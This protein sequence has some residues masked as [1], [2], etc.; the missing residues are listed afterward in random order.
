MD[1]PIQIPLDE[2]RSI[3]HFNAWDQGRRRK[4]IAQVCSLTGLLY[5]IFAVIPKPWATPEAEAVMRVLY[6]LAIAPGL[7][8]IAL[9]SVKPR[10]AGLIEPLLAAHTVLAAACHVYINSKL[11]E[12]EPLLAEAYLMLV[13]TFIISGLSPR[14]ALLSA[15]S[16]LL[17]FS[18]YACFALEGSPLFYIHFFW[19]SCSFLFGMVG[20]NIYD[21]ARRAEFA[22]QLAYRE[23]AL[24]DP[25][26][27]CFNRNELDRRLAIEIPRAEREQQSFS[28]LMLDLDKFKL[29][30]DSHGHDAGDRV[31]ETTAS[32]IRQ[33]IRKSDTLIRW[34]GEEFLLLTLNQTAD[35]AMG[36]AEK[37]RLL[38]QTHQYDNQLNL[39]VSIGVTIYYPG[40]Q[41]T[42]LINR[43][44][45]GL[46]L[47]KS[48]GRNCCRFV[49]T[50]H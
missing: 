43:A 50:E 21:R 41:Q 4:Q 9:L 26:T 22:T 42:D 30:N 8:G 28:V 12:F 40:D 2:P 11:V 15:F 14:Y 10:F 6:P 49:G 25:L 33:S 29:V 47:A 34:G 44:D 5:L 45:R 19:L 1:Q 16:S 27:K 35:Q 17:I 3:E 7:L 39:T 13:W 18:V 48:E 36:M 20:A 37:L 24:T 31:L 32:I 23:L 46:Y 38:I